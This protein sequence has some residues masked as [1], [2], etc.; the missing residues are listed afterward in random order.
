MASPV[1]HLSVM[2][3]ELEPRSS[4][5]VCWALCLLLLLRAAV[6]V[7]TEEPCSGNHMPKALVERIALLKIS[8]VNSILW[9]QLEQLESVY[10]IS[11]TGKLI[12]ATVQLSLFLLSLFVIKAQSG[13][14]I[15]FKGRM[16]SRNK[17]RICRPLTL[18]GLPPPDGPLLVTMSFDILW[19][20]YSALISVD[21]FISRICLSLAHLRLSQT[22]AW[23]FF[24][25]YWLNGVFL[26]HWCNSLFSSEEANATFPGQFCRSLDLL[27]D[28]GLLEFIPQ[29]GSGLHQWKE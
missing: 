12:A 8:G 27:G 18:P 17:H 20:A 19:S 5:H 1:P 21:L 26:F 11:H 14:G 29:L 22:T 25:Y 16:A 4:Q 24:Q 6:S 10:G 15:W 3:V 23:D 28:L 9:L 2:Q 7:P 13:T